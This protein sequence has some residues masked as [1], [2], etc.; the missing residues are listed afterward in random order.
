MTSEM[1]MALQR[2]GQIKSSDYFKIKG[3]PEFVEP[4]VTELINL[5][6]NYS[7]VQQQEVMMAVSDEVSSVLGWYA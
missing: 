2:L 7:E 6:A 3:M 5:F 1:S 4:L